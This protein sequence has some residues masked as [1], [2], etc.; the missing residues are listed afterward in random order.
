MSAKHQM[1][2]WSQ[3][4]MG[5]ERTRSLLHGRCGESLCDQGEERTHSL[6]LTPWSIAQQ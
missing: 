4:V 5:L 3:V 1:S 2:A 6:L